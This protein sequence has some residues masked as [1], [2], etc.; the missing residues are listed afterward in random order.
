[1]K[2][3]I[4]IALLVVVAALGIWLWL[5]LFP[6]PDKIIRKRLGEFARVVSFSGPESDFARLNAARNLGGYLAQDVEVNVDIP[7]RPEQE[8]A[9]RNEIVQ[10]DVGARAS[11]QSLKVK[12][13]DINVKLSPDKLSAVANLTAIANWSGERD[14]IIQELKF[15]LAISDGKWVI[16]RVETLKTL[17]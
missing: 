3:I 10:A 13:Q 12:F 1:V 5:V 9:S 15:T 7:G 16:T 4:R 11:G 14:S 2:I 6:G 8:F 17:S